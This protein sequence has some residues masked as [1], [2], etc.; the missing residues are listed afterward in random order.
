MAKVTGR[1][2][3]VSYGAHFGLY[4]DEEPALTLDPHLARLLRRAKLSHTLLESCTLLRA[5][6][7]AV[8]ECARAL[9]AEACRGEPESDEGADNEGLDYLLDVSLG[10]D[11]SLLL[12]ALRAAPLAALRRYDAEHTHLFR[13][14]AE[15]FTPYA[16]VAAVLDLVP[17]Y[18]T[19]VDL[20]AGTGRALL[21]AALQR[22]DVRCIGFE[23]VRERVRLT[24]PTR[25]PTCHAP[26]FPMHP[27]RCWAN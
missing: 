21:A 4:P 25:T 10:L 17:V 19:L 15:S 22:P 26:C 20:G 6:P 16:E 7:Q 13:P 11:E 2:F 24:A 23:T 14:P 27:G 1:V 3:P 5:P 12:P 8:R 9:L 18:G